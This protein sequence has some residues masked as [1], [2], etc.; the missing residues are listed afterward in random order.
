LAAELMLQDGRYGTA[1]QAA[2]DREPVKVL[3]E[4]GAD[5]NIIA[6]A[7]VLFL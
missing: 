3:L 2:G 1:L 5:P 7:I 4:H 6:G